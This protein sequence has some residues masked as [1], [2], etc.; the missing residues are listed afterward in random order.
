MFAPFLLRY[1]SKKAEEKFGGQFNNQRAE[2]AKKE[3]EV[4]IDKMPRQKQSNKDVGDYVD[5][6]EID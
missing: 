2:P 3:G 4:T 1:V 6:E 5:Y